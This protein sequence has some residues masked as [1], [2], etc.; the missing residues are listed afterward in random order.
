MVFMLRP[1]RLQ[2]FKAEPEDDSA[3]TMK[4]NDASVEPDEIKNQPAG[5]MRVI[6]HTLNPLAPSSADD[7][8]GPLGE[9]GAHTLLKRTPANYLINQVYGLWVY[10]SLFL[11]TILLTRS[12]TVSDYTIYVNAA[13]AFN[14]IAYIVAFGLEDAT[15]TFVPRL[16]AEY[17]QATA[18][19]LIRRLLLI[20]ILIL[21]LTLGILLFSLPALAAFFALI[22]TELTANIATGLRDPN[23]Q[24]H[25]APVAFW[26]L[27]NG[28]F[29]LLNAVYAALMRMKV[30]FIVGGLGQLFLL[31]LGYVMLHLGWGITGVLWL[32]G[33][34]TFI[35]AL[36][37]ALWLSPLLFSRGEVYRQPLGPVFRLGLAAWFTNLV[38]GALLKQISLLL[39]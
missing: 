31:G 3:E 38:S 8:T 19:S 20:R 30:V 11:F 33:T 15:T 32:Q 5:M 25:I 10:L 12:T 9:D 35:G 21:A 27:A 1:V 17:G 26:V 7:I 36:I 2:R 39:L 23:L 4:G 13:A 24:K 29:G 28:I 37:F 16:A 18:A 6:T 22:P 34:I 14:T